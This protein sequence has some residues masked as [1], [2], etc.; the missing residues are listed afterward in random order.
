ME[1][2]LSRQRSTWAGTGGAGLRCSSCRGHRGE[3][4]GDA[5]R[6]RR[7]A[8][9]PASL[10]IC[11]CCRR[12]AGAL[13]VPCLSLPREDTRWGLCSTEELQGVF[14]QREALKYP[15]SSALMHPPKRG[16]FPQNVTAWE[17]GIGPAGKTHG[18]EPHNLVC[19][20]AAPLWTQAPRMLRDCP[21]F[22]NSTILGSPAPCPV[23]ARSTAC[24][25][26]DM[27]CHHPRARRAASTGGALGGQALLR[28]RLSPF[29][30]SPAVRARCR[31][32]AAL[33]EMP[34][35]PRS[36][37][38]PGPVPERVPGAE[39]P[40]AGPPGSRRAV[41]RGARGLAVPEPSPGRHR[42]VTEP[43]CRLSTHLMSEPLRCRQPRSR[44]RLRPRT[45]GAGGS[46]PDPAP[47]AAAGPGRGQPRRCPPAPRCPRLLPAVLRCP[48]G[49]P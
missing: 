14:P 44:H 33:R 3:A 9:L 30:R 35:G 7:T 8:G 31:A 5:G 40:L 41:P 24:P 11:P 38:E 13:P 6:G 19:Q 4:A 36:P 45:P 37:P 29:P 34:R 26:P 25:G 42:A 16:G 2:S 28:C 27:R 10:C 18:R 39:P 15:L 46:A 47:P 21:A 32:T 12:G 1:I 22:T 48:P 43:G 20:P 17:A 23:P 49:P